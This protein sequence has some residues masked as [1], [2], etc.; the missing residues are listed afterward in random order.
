MTTRCAFFPY[1]A[2]DFYNEK[3]VEFEYEN[4]LAASQRFKSA[5]NLRL[6]A[7][8]QFPSQNGL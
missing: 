2:G 6:A 4:G 5:G 8:E 3:L 1:N 7:L